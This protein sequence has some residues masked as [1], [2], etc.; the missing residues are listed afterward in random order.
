MKNRSKHIEITIL[1]HTTVD[2]LL[3]THDMAHLRQTG[4]IVGAKKVLFTEYTPFKSKKGLFLADSKYK[5]NVI[6]N[7]SKN[8]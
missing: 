6:N 8:N 3:I 4:T 7:L 1:P 2:S 5:Q